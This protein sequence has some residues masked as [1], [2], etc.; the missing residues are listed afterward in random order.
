MVASRAGL[1]DD[2][3]WPPRPRSL[4]LPHA[5]SVPRPHGAPYPLRAEPSTRSAGLSTRLAD[6]PVTLSLT[7]PVP[8]RP[9]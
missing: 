3:R 5:A 1:A 4:P 7:P 2:L 9:A 8:A 6:D